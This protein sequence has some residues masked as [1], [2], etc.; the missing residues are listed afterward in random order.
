MEGRRWGAEMKRQVVRE[1]MKRQRVPGK[2]E[3]TAAHKRKAPRGGG[4]G[5]GNQDAQ[6]QADHAAVGI[7]E[8]KLQLRG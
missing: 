1:K 6:S 5:L 3:S 4:E 7:N 2:R 8:E